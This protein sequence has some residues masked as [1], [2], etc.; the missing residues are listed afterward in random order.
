MGRGV[1]EPLVPV[2]V[3]RQKFGLRQ[4][5]MLIHRESKRSDLI[6]EPAGFAVNGHPVVRVEYSGRTRRVGLMRA[7]WIV[8]HNAYPLGAVRPRDGDRW[9]CAP[10][11]LEVVGSGPCRADRSRGGRA[12]S[13]EH[14]AALD[15][16]LLRALAEHEAPSIAH[17]ANVIE[18]S[19]AVTSTKLGKLAARG[20]AESPRCCPGRSWALTGAGRALVVSERPLIDDLDHDILGALAA[21]SMGAMRQ[22]GLSRRCGVCS[23]TIKRRIASL[24]ERGLVSVIGPQFRITDAGRQALPEAQPPSRWIRIEAISAAAAKDVRDR[25]H[26]SDIT[27]AQRSEYSK[28]ARASAKKNGSQPFNHH[29]WAEAS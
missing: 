15:Q 4:D 8:V 9:N 22:L 1:A 14:R 19:E 16:I 21:A 13:L 7:A 6:G 3:I 28:L 18:A 23:L 17:L 20:L 29:H 10:G 24:A 2:A 12:S 26:V 5:G 25:A 27:A 11:N